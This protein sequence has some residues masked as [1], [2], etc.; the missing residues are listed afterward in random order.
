MWDSTSSI[1]PRIHLGPLGTYGKADFTTE[2]QTK[3]PSKGMKIT[4]NKWRQMVIQWW[5]Y[6]YKLRFTHG[7]RK[8]LFLD[9]LQRNKNL[10]NNLQLVLAEIEGFLRWKWGSPSILAGTSTSFRTFNTIIWKWIQQGLDGTWLYCQVGLLRAHGFSL[11][12]KN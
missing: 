6:R 8:N 7:G 10:N 2:N 11:G 3:I 4:K 1:K 5:L 12:T 9:N